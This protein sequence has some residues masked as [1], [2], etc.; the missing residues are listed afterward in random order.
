[1]STPTDPTGAEQPDSRGP[2]TTPAAQGSAQGSPAQGSPAQGSPAQGS[3]PDAAPT[4]AYPAGDAAPTEAYPPVPPAPP[5]AQASYGDAPAAPADG[6]AY[7]QPPYGQPPYGQAPYGAPAP[8]GPDTRPKTLAWISLGLAILGVI[9]SCIGFVPAAWV[10]FAS[11]IVGGLVLLVAFVLSIVALASRKQGGKPIGIAALIV[12]VLSGILWAVAL[13][14][15]FTFS[16]VTSSSD[17]ESAPTPAPSVSAAPED[18]GETEG[19]VSGTYDEEAFIAEARP[20]INDLFTAL[21]PSITEEVVEQM[22]TDET[23]VTTGKSFLLAG[24]AG[25]D[26]LIDGLV[27][28]SQGVFDEDAATQFTD[29]ILDAAQKHL[30]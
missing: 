4:Q 6:P 27:S 13:I 11:V 7:G 20:A 21:D 12:S 10:G 26:Q 9:L 15:A 17:A 30:Q 2:E 28:G 18:E 16:V 23:L 14:F 19:E 24:E 25:R 8:S 1:M 3:A 22:F 29:I 5:V